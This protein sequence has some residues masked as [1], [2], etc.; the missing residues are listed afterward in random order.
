MKGHSQTYPFSGSKCFVP[1]TILAPY[2]RTYFCIYIYIY[3]YAHVY[4][5]MCIYMHTNAL[6]SAFCHAT[7][8]SIFGYSDL[9]FVVYWR[10]YNC[11]PMRAWQN[12]SSGRSSYFW[13][14][15]FLFDKEKQEWGGKATLGSFFSQQLQIMPNKFIK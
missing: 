8:N 9:C 3:I 4:T 12:G 5:Y 11:D 1:G 7:G 2:L 6:F 15:T 10:I 13:L 14:N